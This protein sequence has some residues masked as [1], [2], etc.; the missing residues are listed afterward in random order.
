MLVGTLPELS[1]V[2]RFP[3]ERRA[4]KTLELLR[5]IA[6]DVR[7][8]MAIADTFDLHVPFYD[9]RDRVDAETAQ[10]IVDQFSGISSVALAMLDEMLRVVLARAVAACHAADGLSAEARQARDKLHRAVSAGGYW[11]DPLRARAE[12]LTLQAAELIVAAHV[13]VEEAE[14][15][16]RAVGMARRG[17]P[18][19]PYN[20]HEEMEE[21]LR[22]A[23]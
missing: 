20:V 23:I 2:V 5:E 4:R 7:E 17:Q 11:L 18:W 9:L 8:V 14:G 6:P 21:L 19:R 13:A 3:V 10:Y 22:M 16:A 1:N 12:A 15:V